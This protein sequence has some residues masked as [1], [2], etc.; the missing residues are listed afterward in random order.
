MQERVLANPKIKV[1]WNSVILD[2][3]GEKSLEG[4][5]VKNV[6]TGEVSKLEAKG[7]FYAIGHKPNTAFLKGI[8]ELDDEGYVV[9]APGSSRTGGTA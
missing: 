9:T 1:V 6:R 8:M 2:A 4:V 5:V 3:E 7:L